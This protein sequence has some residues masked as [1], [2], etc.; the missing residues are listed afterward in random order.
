[1]RDLH[2]FNVL[3]QCNEIEEDFVVPRLDKDQDLYAVCF[4]LSRRWELDRARSVEL[5][6][7]DA[8]SVLDARLANR[9]SLR[10]TLRL[11]IIGSINALQTSGSSELLGRIETY[12]FLCRTILHHLALLRYLGLQS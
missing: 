12:L 10:R 4:A 1:M 7:R 5:E 8:F 9:G 6:R 3:E 11:T 2:H